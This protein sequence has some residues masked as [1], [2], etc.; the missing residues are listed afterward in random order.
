VARFR[1]EGLEYSNVYVEDS[2]YSEFLDELS[3]LAIVLILRF[4][5]SNTSK[6]F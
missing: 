6:I 5:M 2:C 1:I 4:E 3:V